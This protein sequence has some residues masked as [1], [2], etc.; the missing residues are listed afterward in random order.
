MIPNVVRGSGFRGCLDYVFSQLKTPEVVASNMSSDVPRVLAQEFGFVRRLNEKA[1]TAVWHVSL[2]AAPDERFDEEQWSLIVEKFIDLVGSK[3]TGK[4][5]GISSERNQFIAVRHQDTDHDHVHIVLN[6]VN[7]DAEVCYCKW[8]RNRTQ[9]ACREIEKSFGLVQVEGKTKGEKKPG[10]L[11]R[12]Q[13]AILE[14]QAAL[15]GEVDPRLQAYYDQKEKGAEERR[16][17]NNSQGEVVEAVAINLVDPQ[18][19]LPSKT[20]NSTSSTDADSTNEPPSDAAD[21]QPIE[22]TMPVELPPLVV[23]ELELVAPADELKAVVEPFKVETQ[24]TIE[25]TPEQ[26]QAAD[27]KQFYQN[28]WLKFSE[29]VR[30]PTQSE[31]LIAVAKVALG[32]K[33]S[34][35]QTRAIVGQ[36]PAI[37]KVLKEKGTKTAYEAAQLVVK[38]AEMKRERERK[39]EGR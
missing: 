36:S 23:V 8:D 16:A 27:Q 32:R 38:E 39:E 13:V 10:S 2:S 33:Y 31:V 24:P 7:Y 5:I 12:Q 21:E 9:E 30:K 35:D 29:G 22:I 14:K 20:I 28:L 25:L 4:E 17:K 3:A 26:Q 18:V 37:Q 6:R 1:T 15:T 11:N 34:P 19:E